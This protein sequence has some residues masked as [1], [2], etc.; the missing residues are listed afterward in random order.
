[1]EVYDLSGCRENDRVKKDSR[2]GYKIQS[3]GYK[4]KYFWS[5]YTEPLSSVGFKSPPSVLTKSL[6][7]HH[8]SVLF[9]SKTRII[10]KKTWFI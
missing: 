7:S 5:S 4:Y 10:T 6:G 8:V 1:M 3:Q 2:S 9:S